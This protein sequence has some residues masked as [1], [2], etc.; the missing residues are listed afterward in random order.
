MDY[1]SGFGFLEDEEG[2]PDYDNKFAKK[3]KKELPKNI[4]KW[5]KDNL[6]KIENIDD[7]HCSEAFI[8]DD[9][10]NSGMGRIYPKTWYDDPEKY[11]IIAK[12]YIEDSEKYYLTDINRTKDI[13]SRLEKGETV[14]NWTIKAAQKDIKESENKIRED[15]EKARN[16]KITK[17][18]V[19][20][21]PSFSFYEDP[22]PEIISLIKERA[23][24]FTEVFKEFS[25][26][27]FDLEICCVKTTYEKTAL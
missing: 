1:I 15:T 7:I 23:K 17:Y 25:N 3:A 4:F 8:N 14:S 20:D 5:L 18:S 21:Y 19:T 9:L 10:F 6:L 12:D 24:K 16:K 11:E 2:L 26:E 13:I 27:K 22:S